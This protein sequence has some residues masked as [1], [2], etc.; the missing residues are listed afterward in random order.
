MR[1]FNGKSISKKYI[2][3]VLRTMDSTQIFRIVHIIYGGKV[4]RK[5]VYDFIH[6][7]APSIKVYDHAYKIAYNNKHDLLRCSC[8]NKYGFQFQKDNEKHI[9]IESLK[10][11]IKHQGTPYSKVPLMGHTHLY[12][13]SPVYGHS[14]YNKWRACEIKGNERFCEL[15]ISVAKKCIANYND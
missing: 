10:D 12:F 15:I 4:E 13:C 11:E 6:E 14:D 5:Q 9:I 2:Q 7:F 8:R 3:T 1:T